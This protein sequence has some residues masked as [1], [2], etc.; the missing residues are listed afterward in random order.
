MHHPHVHKPWMLNGMKLCILKFIL[1]FFTLFCIHFHIFSHRSSMKRVTEILRSASIP[2]ILLIYL[3]LHIL[4]K[5]LIIFAFIFLV[6]W[7]YL[8]HI[9]FDAWTKLNYITSLSYIMYTE[10][11]IAIIEKAEYT[12]VLTYRMKVIKW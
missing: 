6:S 10:T 5:T 8:Q 11:T 3:H 12:C 7:L 9:P 1:S 2:H 4:E